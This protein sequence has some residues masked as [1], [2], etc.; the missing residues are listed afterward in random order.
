M[1][2]T[3]LCSTGGVYGDFTVPLC[4]NVLHIDGVMP[5]DELK[6]LMQTSDFHKDESRI[7]HFSMATFNQESEH[8]KQKSYFLTNATGRKEINKLIDTNQI[9]VVIVHSWETTNDYFLA[10]DD[11]KKVLG[12]V[13]NLRRKIVI[14]ENVAEEKGVASI[15][16]CE[17][18]GK[19]EKQLQKISD[20]TFTITQLVKGLDA[21]IV[22]ECVKYSAYEQDI[23]KPFS[24]SMSRGDSNGWVITQT[25]VSPQIFDLIIDLNDLTNKT[26][27]GIAADVGCNQSTVCRNIAKAKAAGIID[28]NGKRINRTR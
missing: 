22:V 18:G 4:K 11:E 13:R 12:W 19:G 25:D 6:G 15:L 9:D 2:M 26:Q 5:K 21:S 23:P 1:L 17:K 20:V 3:T 7:Y 28:G 24:F 8:S 10:G 14:E 16:Y 27:A